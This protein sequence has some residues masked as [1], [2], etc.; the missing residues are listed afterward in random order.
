MKVGSPELFVQVEL[1]PPPVH[2]QLPCPLLLLL[3]P[4]CW[5]HQPPMDDALI[6][7]DQMG[8]KV[9]IFFFYPLLI[10]LTHL[11]N[12]DLHIY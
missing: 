5:R 2:L 10:L 9:Y 8:I 6:V 12:C 3:A 1:H 11:Y 4:N 7:F